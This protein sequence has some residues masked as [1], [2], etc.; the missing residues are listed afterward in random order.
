MTVGVAEA[1]L[2]QDQAGGQSFAAIQAYAAETT[3]AAE[4]PTLVEASKSMSHLLAPL[5]G[6]VALV[7]THSYVLSSA[8]SSIPG[9]SA[10]LTYSGGFMQSASK[11]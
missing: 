7:I 8:L 1:Q 11:I 2:G 3:L 5:E 4:V 10:G 6:T 9:S